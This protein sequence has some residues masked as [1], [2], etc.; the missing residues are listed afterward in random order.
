MIQKE[1]AARLA[2]KP[3]TKD[4]GILTLA[5]DIVGKAKIKFDVPPTCFF[6]QPRVTS[7]IIEISFNE[8]PPEARVFTSYLPLIRS[9]FNQ[10]RKTLRNALKSYIEPKTGSNIDDFIATLEPGIAKYFSMRAEELTKEDFLKLNSLIN[11]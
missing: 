3:R 4:Y 5:L 2:A 11:L 9:A 8:N 6:P 7:S 1:V 10:R